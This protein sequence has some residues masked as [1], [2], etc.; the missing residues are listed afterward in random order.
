MWSFRDHRKGL[1]ISLA[2]LLLLGCM[3]AIAALVTALWPEAS[4]DVCYVVGAFSV[5]VSHA[6]QGYFM[7]R[8]EECDTA[9]KMRVIKGD[10]VY[11]YDLNN[12]GEYEVF[13]LQM[14]SGTYTCSL[15]AH[16]RDGKYKKDAEISF[17]VEM[18]DEDTAYLYPSQYVYYTEDS[19]AVQASEEICEGLETDEEKIA[20]I[21]AYM[22]DNY[23]YDY[24]RAA[25]GPGFYL[26]DVDGC[27]ED[28]IGLCQDLSAVA[29]CM[30]RV[31]GI[32]TQMVIGYADRQYHAW[33]SVLIDGEYQRLDMTAEITGVP[34]SV[35]TPER[36]Y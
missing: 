35:Y 33:N 12:E 9:L 7:A 3:G 1:C 28:Q 5:D 4:G 15:Y 24:T 26:G 36:R 31:Q 21:I 13:P 30:L 32:P 19:P 8:R 6:D 17:I 18:E 14:G 11:T 23:A 20:A 2:L 22:R 29:A 10:T 27:F 16:V 34:A 25:V